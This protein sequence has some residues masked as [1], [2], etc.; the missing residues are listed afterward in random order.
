MVSN[1]SDFERSKAY[2]GRYYYL[3]GVKYKFVKPIPS[4]RLSEITVD[5]LDDLAKIRE[6]KGKGLLIDENGNEVYHSLA[7]IVAFF[8]SES[9]EVK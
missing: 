4:Y 7:E 9:S 3:H 6:P 8:D 1:Q 2:V 5:N